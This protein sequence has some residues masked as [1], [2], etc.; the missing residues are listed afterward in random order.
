MMLREFANELSVLFTVAR[1]EKTTI[2]DASD[3]TDQRK[4]DEKK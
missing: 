1:E 3:A 2:G 4:A